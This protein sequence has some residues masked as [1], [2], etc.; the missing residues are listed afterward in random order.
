MSSIR[1]K[2]RNNRFLFFFLVTLPFLVIIFTVGG[3]LFLNVNE[4]YRAKGC[5]PLK[6]DVIQP[7]DFEEQQ[8]IR[9]A[10]IGDAGTGDEAQ[11]RIAQS[12][13]KVCLLKGCNFVLM[14]GDN[15]YP[16]GI[17]SVT[18]D[19]FKEK[20]ED[21]YRNFKIPFFAVLGNHDV[22]GDPNAQLY[23][24]LNSEVWR[25]PNFYYLFNAGPASFLGLNSNCSPFNWKEQQAK[26]AKEKTP[27]KFVF[28]HHTIYSSGTH[29]NANV[30]LRG[31]WQYY[32]E[33]DAD[34]YIS[35]HDH[36]LE[37]L[38]VKG[39]KTHF[40]VSGAGGKNYSSLSERKKTNKHNSNSKFIYQNNGFV[41]FEVAKKQVLVDFF[42]GDGK[43]LY[44]FKQI[45]K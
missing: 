3:Y 36:Q 27:W 34:F 37:H 2:R 12:L 25:M 44:Q 7:F 29:G 39:Q 8:D 20:F 11:K 4:T 18:D 26:L 41:L 45:K 35:G 42:D 32:F 9:F 38:Q 13:E 19:Q 31:L 15:F 14:L 10:A 21:I 40:I 6:K 30:L 5:E 43:S 16:D 28:G 1:R 33:E 22:H 24:S 23:R 17:H